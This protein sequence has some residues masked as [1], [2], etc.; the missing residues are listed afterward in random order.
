M[1][2]PL[3]LLIGSILCANML[4]NGFGEVGVSVPHINGF[5][6]FF[7]ISVAH[8]EEAA[9]VKYICPM[10][11]Q[12]IS[13]EHGKCPI[14]GMDLV[15]ID[16]H[17]DSQNETQQK[18]TNDNTTEKHSE[19]KVLYWYDPM[20]PWKKFDKSGKSPFMDME[21][22]PKYADAK[23]SD[24]NG[25]K[26][27]ISVSSENIQKMGVRT[28]KVQKSTVQGGTRVVGIVA[29][30]ERARWEM[31]SQVEGRVEYL[32]Y[33][34]EGDHMTK[35]DLFY[36]LYSPDILVLQNDYISA[37]KAGLSDLAAAAVKRMKLLGVDERVINALKKTGK[38]YDEV[39]F[40]VPADGVL[41]TLKIRN[42]SYLT[43]GDEI[44]LVQDLSKVW[45]EA[46]VSEQDVSAIKEKQVAKVTFAGKTQIYDAVV[47]YIY[48]VLNTETRTGKVRLIVENTNGDLK[49][50]GY[51]TVEFITGIAA[52]RLIV[53]SEAILRSSKGDHV[54]MSLGNG[55][56][57]TRD[58]KIGITSGGKTEIIEGLKEGEDVVT[59]AQF[60]IDSESSLRESLQ[61][62]SGEK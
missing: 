37:E 19:R 17:Y 11:P 6:K 61:N 4:M 25:G 24:Q 52:E 20:V 1:K 54:I 44:G 13:D 42:G 49:P 2:K 35:G 14:C 39:P 21:L 30:N 22:V 62:L 32:K 51:A 57:R 45:V 59:S 28:G 48:P 31:F 15:A 56:F 16:H 36:T 41:A 9:A 38:A 43:A 5:Q 26:P 55:K 46:A 8:A 3:P 40:Y 23:D 33:S 29:P 60:L 18:E 27:I 34:A 7:G 47:D 58:V 12:I 50:A 53:P 10:H